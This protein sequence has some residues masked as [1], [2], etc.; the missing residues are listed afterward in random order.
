M[1]PPSRPSLALRPALCR[2]G[3][4]LGVG[5][6]DFSRVS[7]RANGV[8][9]PLPSLLVPASLSRRDRDIDIE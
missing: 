4:P 6:P 9:T 1:G 5:M 7:R 8:A 3:S 2:L